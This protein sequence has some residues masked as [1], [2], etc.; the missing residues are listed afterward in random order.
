MPWDKID[1]AKY[2]PVSNGFE[3]VIAKSNSRITANDNFKLID[4]N[5]K[6]IFERKD[7][8]DFDLNLE[9]FKAKMQA[10]DEKAKKFKTISEFNNHLQFSWL[11]YE[12]TLFENDSLSKEKRIRWHE[13]M[14]KDIY[15]NE[16]FN[17]LVD[18]QT[19]SSE[20]KVVEVKKKKK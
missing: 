10:S 15:I 5:A 19:L 2:T 14:Q 1:P 4:E 13:E 11:P 3:A 7:D 17:I 18:I 12:N 20:N 8:N 16:A 6:W 9:T